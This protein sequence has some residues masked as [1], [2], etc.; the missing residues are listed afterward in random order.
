MMI[1]IV[2]ELVVVSWYRDE[3]FGDT[4]QNSSVE[5][6]GTRLA[7]DNVDVGGIAAMEIRH[8]QWKAG[9]QAGRQTGRQADRQAGRQIGRQ[10]DRQTAD[11]QTSRQTETETDRQRERAR[12]REREPQ[13]A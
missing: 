3:N 7:A 2:Q 1:I 8:N 11:R 5:T 9:R 4:V 12:E 6:L 13:K 10:T